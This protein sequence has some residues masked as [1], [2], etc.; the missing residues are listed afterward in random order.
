MESAFFMNEIKNVGFTE[1]VDSFCPVLSIDEHIY[2]GVLS[3]YNE[4][5]QMKR[6]VLKC[7]RFIPSCYKMVEHIYF[8]PQIYPYVAL[9]KC[10]AMLSTV[11]VVVYLCNVV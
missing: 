2:N 4:Q 6:T 8:L 1:T 11:S 9:Y 5:S 3:I 7:Y 10:K